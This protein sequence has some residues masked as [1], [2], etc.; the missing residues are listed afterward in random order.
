MGRRKVFNN[1]L[2]LQLAAMGIEKVMVGICQFHGRMPMDHTLS[3]LVDTL[4]SVC[5]VNDELAGMVKRIE[6]IDDM[7]TLSPERRIPPGDMDIHLT[8]LAGREVASFAKR[9][10]PREA[11][12]TAAA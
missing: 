1:E 2:I 4:A 3:G 12:D 5:P 10:L 8:L 6:Q 7:C 11:I 9:V